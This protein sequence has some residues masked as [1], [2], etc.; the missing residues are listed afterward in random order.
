MC[1]GTIAYYTVGESIFIYT[2]L[3][4]KRGPTEDESITFLAGGGVSVR[5]SFY[6]LFSEGD[7]HI[8]GYIKRLLEHHHNIAIL[9]LLCSFFVLVFFLSFW[10]FVYMDRHGVP[11]LFLLLL[12]IR[13][14]RRVKVLC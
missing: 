14:Y 10:L 8:L 12:L 6:A 13:Y 4:Y 5:Y 11:L 9:F 3:C 1:A 7:I 2:K